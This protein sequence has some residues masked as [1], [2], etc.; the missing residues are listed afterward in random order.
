[1]RVQRLRALV[2]ELI[3][4]GFVFETRAT[5]T[6]PA[7]NGELFV[8]VGDTSRL[9][10]RIGATA[11]SI[12]HYLQQLENDKLSMLLFDASIVQISYKI[13]GDDVLKHRYCYI[14]APCVVDLRAT[15]PADLHGVVEG[16]VSTTAMAEPRRSVLRFEYD[17]ASQSNDHPA[18]HLHVN[19]NECRLPIKAPLNVKDFVHFLVKYM[20][21]DQFARNLIAAEFAGQCTLSNEEA[22]GFHLNWG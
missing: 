8:E 21:S 3:S 18:A 4:S 6:Y 20:Y 14:P 19:S 1:M 7:N 10:I 2:E 15:D 5:K 11:N 13:R 22:L 9:P 12:A 17:P 16:M